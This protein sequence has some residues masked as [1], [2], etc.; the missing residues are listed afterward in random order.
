MPYGY[1]YLSYIIF[2]LPAILLTLWA[3]IKVKST[4]Q[5]YSK[6]RSGRNITGR[7]AARAILDSKGL[8]NVSIEPT[9]GNLT[10]HYDPRANVIR[11]SESTYNSSSVAAIG[12]A[13]H[14]AGHAIQYAEGY[15]PIKLRTSIIPVCNSAAKTAPLLLLIGLIFA[16]PA[17]FYAGIIAFSAA[18]V[19]Q[20]VTL[21]VE[22]NA[23]SRAI[24]ILDGG[25]LDRDEARDAKKV[26]DAAALTYVAALVTSLM[27]I[28]YY[29]SRFNSRRN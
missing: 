12:V 8:Y 22:F 20:L 19:F 10:D 4:F 3:Q 23:S 24:E 13:A 17:L 6:V 21:P 14:E 26:L 5:K 18:A 11:L 25:V 9:R 28:L 15:G 27:Q 2:M 16:S 29:L 7:D 1:G